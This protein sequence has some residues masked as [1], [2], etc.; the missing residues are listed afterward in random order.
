MNTHTSGSTFLICDLLAIKGF[1]VPSIGQ[2]Q[3]WKR[4]G[5]CKNAKNLMLICSLFLLEFQ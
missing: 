1:A 4:P 3:G 5:S 2:V